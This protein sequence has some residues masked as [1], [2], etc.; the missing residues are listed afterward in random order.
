MPSGFFRSSNRVGDAG[1]FILHRLERKGFVPARWEAAGK[2]LKREF[3]YYCLT[4]RWK[5]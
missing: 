4:G 1:F 3:K 2:D 5:K